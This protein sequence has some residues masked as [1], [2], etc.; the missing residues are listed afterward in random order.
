MST[1][2]VVTSFS[3]IGFRDYGNK[4][5]KSACQFLPTNV[6]IWAYYNGVKP[7]FHNDRV[8][9]IDN[10]AIPNGVS[11]FLKR[12]GKDQRL[13]GKVPGQ[14]NENFRTAICKFSH[15]QYA[16]YHASTVTV[17]DFLVYADADIIFFAD[18][19]E[20][21]F[22]DILPDPHYLAVLD[23]GPKYFPETG[24]FQLR[25]SHLYHKEFLERYIDFCRRDTFLEQR[26]FH[27][28]WLTGVLIQQMRSEGKISIA[29]LCPGFDGSGHPWLQSELARYS[30]HAKGK[31]RKLTGRSFVED[32]RGNRTEPY[33]KNLPSRKDLK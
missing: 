14:A 17:S 15:K 27:D 9:F 7:E 21:F 24:W 29:N 6:E 30:D 31:L 25:T 18:V 28:A 23:R 19:P 20:S 13:W 2:T 8:Q 10:Y 11:D 5:L 33:W 4:M 26:E 16:L 32:V 3:G 22:D 1:V 12:H